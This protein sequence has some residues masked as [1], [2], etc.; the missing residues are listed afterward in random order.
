MMKFNIGDKVIRTKQDSHYGVK[1]G[2]V[3]TVQG[4]AYNDTFKS[5]E[6]SMPAFA[7]ESFELHKSV[8][9]SHKHHDIII[10][11]AKGAKVQFQLSQGGWAEA[12]T[13]CW[14]IDTEYRV[15]VDLQKEGLIEDLS[16]QVSAKLNEVDALKVRIVKLESEL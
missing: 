16:K 9:K 4:P 14:V 13:P 15:A 8:T 5:E 2:D 10:E 3:L 7:N 1:V 11:W 6:H 12:A